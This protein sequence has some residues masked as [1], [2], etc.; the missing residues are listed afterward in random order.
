MEKC[1]ALRTI[2]FNTNPGG[3]GSANLDLGHINIL[4]N[5]PYYQQ[6]GF[7]ISDPINDHMFGG[8]LC[9]ALSAGVEC[10]DNSYP[11]LNLNYND[12]ENIPCGTYELQIDDCFPYYC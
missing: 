11:D 9:A 5:P 4:C 8:Y 3:L 2:S 7:T 1:V 6:P 10:T 12:N